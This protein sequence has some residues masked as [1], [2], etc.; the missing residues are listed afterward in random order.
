MKPERMKILQY[1]S[2]QIFANSIPR[3]EQLSGE[4]HDHLHS[5]CLK[6]HILAHFPD[7]TT[8]KEGHDILLTFN[9]LGQLCIDLLIMTMMM[10]LLFSKRSKRCMKGH[11]KN[12]SIICGL[13]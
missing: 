4:Q 1:S 5:T 7:L 12:A 3:F 13:I 2:S 9:D 8:Q 11:A 6:N 10:K